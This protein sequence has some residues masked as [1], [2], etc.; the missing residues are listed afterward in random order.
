MQKISFV[1][2][3]RMS[4][5]GTLGVM[6][7]P[8]Y[9]AIILCG[10]VIFSSIV[11]LS[12][13]WGL[14]G[15]LLFSSLPLADKLATIGLMISRMFGELFTTTNGFL[16]LTVSILQGINISLI[17]YTI[18][19]NKR[20]GSQ[21]STNKS[22]TKA[23]GGGGIAAIATAIGLGCVPCGTSIILPILSFFFASSVYAVA[24]FAS[25]IVLAIA[26]VLS[27]YAI[28][29]LGFVAFAYVERDK[30]VKEE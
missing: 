17:I 12:I 6:K 19:Q 1:E 27:C 11:Y 14:Y 26:F 22:T 28:Y 5:S 16:L 21:I 18:K 10:V 8:G 29:K 2:K 30:L 3:L 13:N 15:S 4:L 20:T 7:R 9:I 24:D 25:L 23:L